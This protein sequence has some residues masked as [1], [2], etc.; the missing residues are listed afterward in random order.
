MKKI[1]VIFAIVFILGMVASAASI[2]TSINSLK[3]EKEEMQKSVYYNFR[4]G[5]APELSFDTERGAAIRYS[6]YVTSNLFEAVKADPNKSFGLLCAPV[7][8]FEAVSHDISQYGTGWHD[9][10]EKAGLN[11]LVLDEFSFRVFD[12]TGKDK[13]Y[14]L[15]FYLTNIQF[16]NMNRAFAAIGYVRTEKGDQV[17][18]E[19]ASFENN[20]TVISSAR[21][22][23]YL[24]AKALDMAN[25]KGSEIPEDEE[26][27]YRDVLISS[28][29]KSLGQGQVGEERYSYLLAL[30]PKS[31]SVTLA[32]GGSLKL[33]GV[34]TPYAG[35]SFAQLWVSSD[36][37]VVTVSNDGLIQAVA[38]GTATVTLYSAG[39]AVTID[40]TVE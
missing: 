12:D 34:Y 37:S 18:Y 3:K 25:A 11:P 31:G 22:I 36:S 30:A 33:R 21:S 28:T 7:D 15:N 14:F 19:Y 16:G 10:F 29:Y 8:C 9:A 20:A 35:F 17:K 23:A 24:A 5:S 6:M 32:E 38:P 39:K 4:M 13:L 1:V 2:V 27:A 40:V 26:T